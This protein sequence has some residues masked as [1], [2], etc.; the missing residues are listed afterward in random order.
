M[1]RYIDADKLRECYIEAVNEEWNKKAAPVS[2]SN[3]YAHF[4]DDIDDA[5]TADVVEVVRRKECLWRNTPN[6]LEVGVYDFCE[7]W[8]AGTKDEDY[9]SYGTVKGTE[10]GC[11]ENE[12]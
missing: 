4:V 5:P 7:N 1:A 8:D 3:A 12:N 11:E 6:A 9:C 2:W 10:T